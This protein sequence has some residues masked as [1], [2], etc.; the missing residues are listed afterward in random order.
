MPDEN[1]TP[2]PEELAEELG[3]AMGDTQPEQAAGAPQ[4]TDEA[5]TPAVIALPAEP[6][7]RPETPA[8]AARRPKKKAAAKKKAARVVKR[9]PKASRPT[10]AQA[11][12][13]AADAER[14]AKAID[15][16][17]RPPAPSEAD[18]AEQER[19]AGIREEMAEVQ[20]ELEELAASA[21]V[22]RGRLRELTGELYPQM[23]RSDPLVKSVRAHVT[24]QA[25][26]RATRATSPEQIKRILAAAGKAP[27]DAAF[28]RQ[29]ARGAV[30]PARTPRGAPR[31]D[32]TP[33]KE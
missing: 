16:A 7:E 10:G 24:R 1:D 15:D 17:P 23:V 29:R 19:K 2:T 11:E 33:A 4:E 30:R 20:A 21:D 12:K 31:A 32:P 8:Q 27:I 13:K 25:Q 3:E 14:R 26:L 5:S 6:R 22:K 9:E 18:L 28:S